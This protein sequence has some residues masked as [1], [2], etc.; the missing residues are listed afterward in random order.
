MLEK[1]PVESKC[2]HPVDVD[3]SLDILKHNHQQVPNAVQ[4]AVDFLQ[5]P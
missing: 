3:I 2:V 5:C 1:V 4:L